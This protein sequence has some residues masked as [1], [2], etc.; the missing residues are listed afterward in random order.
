M[1]NRKV[2]I[3]MNLIFAFVFATLA[4]LCSVWMWGWYHAD[5]G[6][7][8]WVLH[9]AIWVLTLRLIKDTIQCV[10]NIIKLS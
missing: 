2:V 8:G 1:A 3:G 4:V 9:V 5:A 6:S 10:S 7:Q